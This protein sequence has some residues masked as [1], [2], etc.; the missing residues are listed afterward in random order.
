MTNI[1]RRRRLRNDY[2]KKPC[3]KCYTKISW[4]ATST[5]SWDCAWGEKN[6]W[7]NGERSQPA[8]R[9]IRSN[10]TIFNG[11]QLRLHGCI[12]QLVITPC[13]Y[14][15]TRE[16]NMSPTTRACFNLIHKTDGAAVIAGSHDICTRNHRSEIDFW[17]LSVHEKVIDAASCYF[18]KNA[19]DR[20]PISTAPRNGEW[21]G[22]DLNLE[23][24]SRKPRLGA[25]R[26]RRVKGARPRAR[27]RHMVNY[28]MTS[29]EMG[30]DTTFLRSSDG[31][32]EAPLLILNGIRGIARGDAIRCEESEA[33]RAQQKLIKQ[34][35]RK[36][37]RVSFYGALGHEIVI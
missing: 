5:L 13:M 33:D 29:G 7:P 21:E 20:H 9:K 6:T 15:E 14:N 36:P 10:L 2:I 34:R 11:R 18:C 1:V 22:R 37:Y 24:L 23:T 17:L 35:L 3:A 26:I 8:R 25:G 16:D 30:S 4:N 32:Y 27:A 28:R 31:A 19:S 12:V